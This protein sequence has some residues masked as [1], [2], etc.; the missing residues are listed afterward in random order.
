MGLQPGVVRLRLKQVTGQDLSAATALPQFHV[1][2]PQG[3]SIVAVGF[4][5][6]T[7]ADGT[8]LADLVSSIDVSG[9]WRIQLHVPGIGNGE[10]FPLPVATNL[11]GVS[12]P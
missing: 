11:P 1:S 8:A 3:G 12:A 6:T 5:E 9:N 2:T 10:K 4:W 7:P